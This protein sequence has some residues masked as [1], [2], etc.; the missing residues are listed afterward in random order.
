MKQ[1]KTSEKSTVMGEQ[2][3]VLKAR[4]QNLEKA[5]EVLKHK[6]GKTEEDKALLVAENGKLHEDLAKMKSSK[7]RL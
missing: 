7:Q 5:Y 3:K 1:S 4:V 6:N 2:T